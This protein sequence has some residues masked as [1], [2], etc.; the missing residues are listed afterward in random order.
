MEACLNRCLESAVGQ[1][2]GNLDIVLINDGSTDGSLDIGLNWAKRDSRVTV[3]NQ[4]NA[5][6]GPARN[7]GLAAARF[8]YLTFLDADDW[9]ENT[10]VEKILNKMLET[11]SDMGLC[12]INYVESATLLKQVAKIRFQSELVCAK[13]DRTVV[14][15]ARIFAW[16]KIYNKELF[17]RYGLRFPACSFEDAPCTPILVATAA[18][19]AYVPEALCNYFRHRTG[20]LS[21]DAKNIDDIGK[22]LRLLYERLRALGLDDEFKLEFKKI[23]LGQIRFAFRKWGG[24]ANNTISGQLSNLARAAAEFFPSLEGFWE[25]KYFAVGGPLLTEALDKAIPLA[26]QIAANESEADCLINIKSQS[27]MS[28]DRASAVWALAEAIMENL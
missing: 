18:Q 17:E 9:W 22:T 1:T 12:D 19:I 21:N 25:R 7:S 24:S 2:Y 6:L 15:K 14:N 8:D 5:G 27:V 26:L 13:Q 10:F 4:L 23:L 11:N 16:G 28:N 3:I 20:S